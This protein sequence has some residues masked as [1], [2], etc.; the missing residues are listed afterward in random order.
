MDEKSA[1]LVRGAL[2]C[3]KWEIPTCGPM[4][5]LP[6]YKP[7]NLDFF[8]NFLIL[9]LLLHSKDFFPSYHLYKLLISSYHMPQTLTDFVPTIHLLTLVSR[10]E[11]PFGFL[12]DLSWEEQ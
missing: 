7:S 10:F 4:I 11:N 12:E 9:Q 1:T 6:F 3:V 5:K 2:G 8:P